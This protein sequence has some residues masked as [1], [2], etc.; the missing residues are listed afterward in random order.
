M[1]RDDAQ[2]TLLLANQRLETN[3]DAIATLHAKL[4]GF[5]VSNL[6]REGF[7]LQELF[8]ARAMN[9]IDRLLADQ[10]NLEQQQQESLLRFQ[11]SER[12][13]RRLERYR[14]KQFTQFTEELRLQEQK[15]LDEFSVMKQAR[16]LTSDL[17]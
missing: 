17:L 7:E 2:R 6:S 10:K 14:E 3:R 1:R 15:V 4:D 16:E 9:Q 13:V 12:E 11:E 5:E 8:R